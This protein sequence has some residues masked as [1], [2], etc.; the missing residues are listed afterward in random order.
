MKLKTITAISLTSLVGTEFKVLLQQ[1][2]YHESFTSLNK[3]KGKTKETPRNT[4]YLV[5]HARGDILIKTTAIERNKKRHKIKS[6]HI[7]HQ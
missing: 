3:T 2:N 4:V 1:I 7:T 6:L 5:S